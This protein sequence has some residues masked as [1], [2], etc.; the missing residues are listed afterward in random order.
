LAA[1]AAGGSAGAQEPV[2]PAHK[3]VAPGGGPAPGGAP[4]AE[5]E[6]LCTRALTCEAGGTGA[7]AA[8]AAL[9]GHPLPG[10]FIGEPGGAAQ[11]HEETEHGQPG[12]SS[13]CSD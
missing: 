2:A 12:E 11:S 5:V 1:L 9:L 13:D 6:D 3:V 7:G 8:R 10:L 4:Y